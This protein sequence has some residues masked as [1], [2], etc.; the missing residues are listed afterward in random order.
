MKPNLIDRV[1]VIYD[2]FARG[3]IAAVLEELSDDAVFGMVGRPSDVPM[4]GLRKGKSG[5][6]D[7][8][9][10]LK[11]TQELRDFS[12]LKFASNEDTVFVLGHTAW[13]MRNN[14]VTGENDWVHIFT[15]DRNG[16]CSGF[17]GHQDTGLLA[18]AYHAAPP[19]ARMAG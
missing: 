9:R 19:S 6:A 15:F 2:N 12:P 8:F 16:K 5:A 4:A 18:E 14:G 11:E 7:F 13:T 10:V 1:R 17:Q 3:D